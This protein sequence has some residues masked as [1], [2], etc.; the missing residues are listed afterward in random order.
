LIKVI[1][2]WTTGS[3]IERTTWFL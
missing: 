1:M 3:W 2:V